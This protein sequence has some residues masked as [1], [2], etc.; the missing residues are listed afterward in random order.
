MAAAAWASSF[1]S[2][3]CRS[4]ARVIPVV[5]NSVCSLTWSTVPAVL[6]GNAL[7]SVCLTAV[8]TSLGFTVTP[9]LRAQARSS[10][11][12]ASASSARVRSVSHSSVP[13]VGYDV[14]IES[15]AMFIV[16]SSWETVMLLP[17]TTATTPAGSV[18]A[19]AAAAAA[20]GEDDDAEQPDA[21][22][23]AASIPRW[24]AVAGA[25]AAV[26]VVF[27]GSEARRVADVLLDFFWKS[28]NHLLATLCFFWVRRVVR[29]V[30]FSAALSGFRDAGT[31]A[32]VA[33]ITCHP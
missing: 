3:R 31:V 13:G 1:V 11:S 27:G 19:R 22:R 21:G 30:V 15:L 4:S 18:A 5:R 33:S 24:S 6:P 28:T 8:S 7:A 25:V 16:V 32:A 9:R 17:S 20:A 2:M 29:I 14:F 12:C 26:L 23:A 10:S